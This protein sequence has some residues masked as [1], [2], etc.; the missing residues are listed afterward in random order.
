[1]RKAFERSDLQDMFSK[2]GA[3]LQTSKTIYLLG[4]G[5][6]AFRD[7]KTATKDL[8]L[9]FENKH[10]YE[11]FRSVIE[12]LGFAQ[13]SV[14][15]PQYSDMRASGIFEDKNGFRF[16]LFVE[17]VCGALGLSDSM[18]SRCEILG[19]Y[20]RLL[21]K[22]LSNEDI[23]LFKAITQREDDAADIAAIIR[24]SD[25]DWKLVLEECDFQS[26]EYCWHGAVLEKFEILSD[27][28]GIDVPIVKRLEKI[29]SKSLLKNAYLQRKD[30]GMKKQDIILELKK[31]EF[32]EK[33]IEEIGE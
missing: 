33:E 24:S 25:I 29:Y 30:K 32:K 27:R 13:K 15:E 8:D 22:M 1:M 11:V 31:L 23:I 2:I 3:R 5:A 21:I 26:S 7:Q 19:E 17:K 9:V 18:I 20:D 4:G 14:L 16:D 28:F 10:D 12:N 6:M